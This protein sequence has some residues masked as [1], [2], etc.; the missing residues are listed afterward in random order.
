MYPSRPDQKIL[1]DFSHTFK[2]GT[3]TAI[4]GPSGSGKSTVVQLVERFYDPESGEVI[5]DGKNLKNIKLRNYRQQIG[6]VGQ[7]PVLFNTTF[8]KNILMG[9]PDA[10]DADIEEALRKTNAWDFVEKAGGINAN[11]GA[12][13]GQL[14]GG[15]KQRIALARAFIKKPRVLIFDEATSALDKVNEAEVQK[16]I[17]QMKVELGNVTS[18]VI[19]HRLTTVK[20][21]DNIIVLKKGKIVEQGTHNSLKDAGGLYAKLAADQDKTDEKEA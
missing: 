10:T 20:N 8:K 14:S 16:S 15:Q 1:N 11:V 13:G 4:V 7:E 2:V 19:A 6:Y 3:T 5:V 18:I 12:G 21:A 17:D 9:K